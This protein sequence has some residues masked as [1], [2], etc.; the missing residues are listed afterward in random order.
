LK[1]IAFF[2]FIIAGCNC[3]AQKQFLQIISQV[4]KEQQSIDSIGYNKSHPD[5]KSVVNET[6]LISEK[7]TQAGYIEAQIEMSQKINDSTFLYQFQLGKKVS[8]IHIYISN[9]SPLKKLEL[10]DS[11]KDT[12][13]LPYGEIESFLKLTL[14][15]LEKKG[16]A[17]SRLQLINIQK[18]NQNLVA[19]LHAQ[20]EKIRHLDDIIINGYTK[21]PESHKHNLKRI[22]KK[23]VFNQDNLKNIYSDIEKF[24]FVKQTKYPEILFTTDSTKVYTYIEK[25]KSNNFDGFIGFSNNEETKKLTINGYL[26]LTL[27]NLLNTGETFS[28]YWK[29]D[30]N[31]QKTF[32]AKIELPYIFK[33]P[34]GLK[35][36]LNIFKQDSTFQNTQTALD[37]G[38]FFNYNTRLYLGYQSAESSDIQNQNTASISDYENSFVTTQFEFVDFKAD[39][40]LFP[41][42]TKVDFKV[43]IGSR[44]SKLIKNDQ[45]FLNINLKHAFF[46]NDKNNINIKSQNY[47]LNSDVYIVNELYRFGGI[48]SIHGFNENSLQANLFTSLLTEY[49]YIIAPN[50]YV[51]S[52][53]DYGYYQDRTSNTSDNLLG[54]GLGFGLATKNGLFNIVYA[55]GSTKEQAIKGSNSIIHISFKTQ[56]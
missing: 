33:S 47:Y 29:S 9:N 23:K 2:L 49:R 45:I 13:T 14:T 26:D 32:N 18:K 54:L 1:P 38:Y 48:N 50:L 12:I 36:Q 39:E 17:L 24:R 46:L 27:N 40:F 7:L 19:E 20:T 10:F 25:V 56:F 11:K 22:Y 42:K 35:A 4:T 34:F 44:K 52:I 21:F 3:S 51:H 15:R 6:L 53:I 30:G 5:A 55:N 37:L 8:Y 31:D 43:G 16:F 41:E 28:L